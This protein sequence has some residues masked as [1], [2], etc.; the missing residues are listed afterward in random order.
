[1]VIQNSNFKSSKQTLLILL[2]SIAAFVIALFC[3]FPK[4]WNLGY[5]LFL[6]SG[7]WSDYISSNTAS[8]KRKL[9][10]I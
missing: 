7:F 10:I 6:E 1:M 4:D 8:I 5:K 2:K 3:G 9:K